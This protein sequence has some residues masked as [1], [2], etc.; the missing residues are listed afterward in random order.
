ME[1]RWDEPSM[2]QKSRVLLSPIYVDSGPLNHTNI[3]D[4]NENLVDLEVE[5]IAGKKEP[6]V[7]SE[8]LIGYAQIFAT[9]YIAIETFASIF[10][11]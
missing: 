5:S 7:S 11:D 1:A 2:D 4:E 8:L 6:A 10:L 9:L 3:E